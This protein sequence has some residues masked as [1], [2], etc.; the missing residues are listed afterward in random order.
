M[1]ALPTQIGRER[2]DAELGLAVIRVWLARA[3]VPT[4]QLALHD[5]SGLSRLNLVTPAATVALLRA[6]STTHSSQ[7]FHASLPVAGRSGTLAGR[8]KPLTDRV[9]AKS[10]SLTYDASLSGYLTA[11]DGKVFIFSIM[12]NDQTQRTSS[13]RLID[14]ILGLLAAFPKLPPTPDG[15]SH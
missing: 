11:S 6:I 12:C 7:I 5:G 10:G 4:Q 1:A 13:T 3:G 15:K 2:G 8:L 14:E 9:S